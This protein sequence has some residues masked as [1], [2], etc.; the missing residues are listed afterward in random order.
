VNFPH[1]GHLC[2]KTSQFFSMRPISLPTHAA[3][4]KL[5]A[6]PG[7]S[8]GNAGGVAC[9]SA[10]ANYQNK[11]HCTPSRP[12]LPPGGRAA[13]G[14]RDGWARR[15]WYTCPKKG[16]GGRKNLMQRAGSEWRVTPARQRPPNDISNPSRITRRSLGRTNSLKAK[17]Y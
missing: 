8:A 3:W 15:Q 13:R 16:R 4:G 11:A 7:E 1:V 10:R 2:S 14:S 5:H 12:R 9:R 17:K 6:P